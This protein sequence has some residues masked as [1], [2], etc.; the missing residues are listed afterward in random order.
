MFFKYGFYSHAE[1]EVLLT[2]QKRPVYSARGLR[3][4]TRV[5]YQLS[6]QILSDSASNLAVSIAALESAYSVDGYSFGLFYGDGSA[7]SLYVNSADTLG[8]TRVVAG[9]EYPKGDGSEFATSRTYTITLE[10]DYPAT[11]DPLLDYRETVSL[12]GGGQSFVHLQ[13]LTG[14]P[15]KQIVA[16]QTVYRAE[17]SGSS[18]GYG[19]WLPPPAPLWPYA[20]L[21]PQRRISRTSPRVTGRSVSEFLTEWSYAF[22]SATPLVGFPRAG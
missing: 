18:I 11:V 21:Q 15:Q 7:T 9:P 8:G 1:N 14:P 19:I 6:G 22:E 20:E 17:Q 16:Q 3:Q 2:T 13:T 12:F 4:A 10:A 5:T